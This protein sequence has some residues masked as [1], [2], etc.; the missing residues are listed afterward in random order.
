MS[1]DVDI[2]RQNWSPGDQLSGAG[3]GGDMKATPAEVLEPV[4]KNKMCL[5]GELAMSR[6]VESTELQSF[7]LI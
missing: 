2:V 7:A 5:K 6:V 3:C 4:R 1:S